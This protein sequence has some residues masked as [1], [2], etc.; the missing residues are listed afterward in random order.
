LTHGVKEGDPDLEI[1]GVI[2][3]TTNGQGSG[4]KPSFSHFRELKFFFA[5]EMV[6]PPRKNLT[7]K[8]PLKFC[9]NPDKVIV[10]PQARPMAAIQV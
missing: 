4:E 3:V 7:A 10:A 9:T 1:Q 2:P 6:S 5:I 8:A